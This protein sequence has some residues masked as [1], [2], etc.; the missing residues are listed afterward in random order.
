MK[1]LNRRAAENSAD[2]GSPALLI[3]EPPAL[4]CV[5]HYK[6]GSSWIYVILRRCVKDRVVQPQPAVEHFL[7]APV[8]QGKVYPRLYVTREQFEGVELPSRWHRFVVIRDLRDTLVSLYFSYKFSHRRDHLPDA[9]LYF[10]ELL[11]TVD[12]ETGLRATMEQWLP[13]TAVEIQR[14]WL[15]A[16]ERLI[17]YEDLLERDVEILEPLLIDQCELPIAPERLRAAIERTRFDRL[18]GGRGRGQEDVTSHQRKG[19]AGDWRNHFSDKLKSEFKE[20]WGDLL[21][22]TGYERDLDW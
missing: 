10:C 12:A 1:L 4:L 14:S 9:L 16:G 19:I 21:I 13:T 3:E 5:T 17:R 6:A 20:R 22:A 11:Q 7:G 8:R 2:N 18:T 15:E